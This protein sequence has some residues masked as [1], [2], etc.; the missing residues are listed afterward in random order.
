[1]SS[2]STPDE[3]NSRFELKTVLETSRI[4]IES[5]SPE[6]V[7]DNLLLIVMG[8]LLVT[9]A[10]VFLYNPVENNYTL[11]RQKSNLLINSGDKV[12]LPFKQG[13]S[14]NG[15]IKFEEIDTPIPKLLRDM[16][17]TMF[18]N[19]RTSNSHIGY[20]FINK[21]ATGI[22]FQESE[23]Q[24]VE[25]LCII[26]SVAIANSRMFDDLKK[27]NRKLDQRIHELNTLFDLSKEFNLLTDREKISRIFKF[28]LLG[29]LFVRSFFMIYRNGDTLSTLAESNLSTEIC[30]DRKA[31]IFNVT[32][33][34]TI[35]DQSLSHEI[36][37]LA[38]NQIAA[39]VGIT[40]Q[41]KKVAVIGVGKR[42]NGNSYTES[43][44]NFLKSLANLAII[45]IQKTYFLEDRIEKERMEEELSIATSI[46][47]ALLPDPIP[48]IEGLDLAAITVP[49]RQV[50]GDYFDVV[51]T[52]DG[53]FVLAIA[54]VTG[55]GVPAALLMANLQSMLHA[56][57]PV[58]ISLSEATGRINNM[59]HNNTTSD[60]FITFFWGKFIPATSVF[61]YVNAGHNPPLLLPKEEEEFTEL[62]DGGLILGA[63]ETLTPY[64]QSEIEI[65]KGDLVVFYTDGVNEAQDQTGEFEFGERRLKNCIKKYRDYPVE[66]IQNKIIQEVDTFSGGVRFDDITL[67]LFKAR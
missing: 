57:I 24:F 18:F 5:K 22:P 20:L 37:S 31:K 16:S 40:I 54:D 58:D 44:F 38:E 59:I 46:Q 10:A 27:T 36:P 66:E 67:L 62:S 61:R 21:K 15:Y 56:L 53:N 55:K 34:V 45:S 8:K 49:S 13:N 65:Q 35:V 51:Q 7:L 11:S 25:S 48:K 42:L 1:M 33:D 19:L 23:L 60:K 9:K 17:G 50:G 32:E 28:A 26:S 3:Q 41:N 43:D 39:L 12:E 14:S 30:E 63:M 4:L 47:Q 29:Q 2:Q 6:F 64:N 52:P